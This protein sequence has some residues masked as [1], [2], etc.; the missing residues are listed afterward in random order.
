M[1]ET[2]TAADAVRD[3]LT[4]TSYA[5]GGLTVSMVSRGPKAARRII[6]IHGTP[7]SALA[8]ERYIAAPPPG[9]EAIA[10]DRP[11]FG[12]TLPVGAVTSLRAQAAA[13][14]PLLVRRDGHLPIL[15]GHSLGG[16]IAAQVAVD[17]PGRVGGLLILAGSFDPAVEETWAIQYAGEWPLIRS[18][19]PTALRSANRELMALKPE[20]EALAPRLAALRCPVRVI[21]GTKDDNVPYSNV[22]FLRAQLPATADF[23]LTTLPGQNHFIVWN[24]EP[25]VRAVLAAMLAGDAKP[26]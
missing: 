22:A 17:N 14:A 10:I 13:I 25:R 5:A 1:P 9:V 19:L 3:R 2:P 18:I 26:C 24:E 8:W 7:G 11:G 15:V 23:A 12:A 21:H 16:P 6:F 20:L 4:R